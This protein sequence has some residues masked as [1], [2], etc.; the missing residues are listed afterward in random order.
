MLLICTTKNEIPYELYS[1]AVSIQSHKAALTVKIRGLVDWVQEPCSTRMQLFW[2]NV[3]NITPKSL[4][5]SAHT[6]KLNHF[7]APAVAAEKFETKS[8]AKC[9]HSLRS[10]A[11][12][13][14]SSCNCGK[15]V[16]YST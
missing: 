15:E 9:S 6:L 8:S 7:T 3:N 13:L 5:G 10:N 4:L 1:S 11:K 12:A 16:W 2:D 14:Y